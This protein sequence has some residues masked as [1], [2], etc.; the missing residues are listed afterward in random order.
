MPSPAPTLP[1]RPAIHRAGRTNST[2]AILA[3]Q[4]FAS[5]LSVGVW[6]LCRHNAGMKPTLCRFSTQSCWRLVFGLLSLMLTVSVRADMV[7]DTVTQFVRQQTASLNGE[8]SFTMGA[9]ENRVTQA[10]C[11]QMQAFLPNGA[12][13]SG[14][15]NV[16]VRCLGPSTWSVF[17]P[18]RLKVMANY[19]VTARALGAGQSITASDLNEIKGDVT[20]LPPGTLLRPEQV[21]G[22]NVRFALSAGQ[23]LRAEQLTNPLVIR[24]NQSVQ[25]IVDGP[26]FRASSEGKALSNASEGQVVQVKTASGSVVSGL[27]TADGSVSVPYNK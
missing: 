25:L 5:V 22:K 13:L 17:I 27:A 1:R 20:A 24:Q 2:S 19:V 23:P 15:M 7:A 4:P 26:G 21:V 11:Q 16:G 14:S 8:V 9:T 10:P 12:T 6:L 3:A 18:V